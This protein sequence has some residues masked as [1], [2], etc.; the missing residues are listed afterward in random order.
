MR[1]LLNGISR[2]YSET[3]VKTYLYGKPK[4]SILTMNVH[5]AYPEVQKSTTTVCHLAMTINAR[6]IW[7]KVIYISELSTYLTGGRVR[8][9]CR[10]IAAAM[11]MHGDACRLLAAPSMYLYLLYLIHTCVD[12]LDIE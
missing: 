6:T 10:S 11:L 1:I 5:L 9:R 12:C 8:L 7:S 3:C 4:G 2:E